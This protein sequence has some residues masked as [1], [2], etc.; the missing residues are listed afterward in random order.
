MGQNWVLFALTTDP[1]LFLDLAEWVL[2]H[3]GSS[4]AELDTAEKLPWY[5]FGTELNCMCSCWTLLHLSRVAF[6]TS[7]SWILSGHSTS[8]QNSM[9]PQSHWGGYI[10]VSYSQY[11]L[12]EP[13]EHFWLSWCRELLRG[14]FHSGAGSLF[15]HWRRQ[16]SSAGSS[17]KQEIYLRT[18]SLRS[19]RKI[20]SMCPSCGPIST[21]LRKTVVE[22]EDM[23]ECWA[24]SYSYV[25]YFGQFL[26]N[27]GS[28]D[29]TLQSPRLNW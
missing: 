18:L 27:G 1:T 29:S 5:P 28:F 22:I 24:R 11:L 7:T 6:G 14:L 8:P 3:G 16:K 21:R 2:F 23:W 10:H 13:H 19:A 26:E 12:P 20:R 9:T 15:A 4:I 25:Y 17:W